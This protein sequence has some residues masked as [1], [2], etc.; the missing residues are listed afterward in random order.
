MGKKFEEV[1]TPLTSRHKEIIRSVKDAINSFLSDGVDRE[2]AS[3]L[4]RC[5]WNLIYNYDVKTTLWPFNRRHALHLIKEAASLA[6]ATRGFACADL[7]RHR[8][9]INQGVIQA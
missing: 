9:G 6:N 2:R 8:F 5:L 3:E 1:T 7:T 4:T